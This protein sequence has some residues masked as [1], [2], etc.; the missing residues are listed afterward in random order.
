V[1]RLSKKGTQRREEVLRT[2]R[3]LL[4]DEGRAGFSMRRVA[5]RAGMSL[6]NL[7][8]YFPTQ[9]ALVEALLDSILTQ[10]LHGL[11]QARGRARARPGREALAALVDRLLR[12]HR[13]PEL[14]RLFF[15]IWSL[16][17]H[18][19]GARR[20][21]ARFYARYRAAIAAEL[22]ATCPRPKAR[23]PD[24][25][26]AL[27]AL[28]EGSSLF[29]VGVAGPV[30][31]A[32]WTALRDAALALACVDERARAPGPCGPSRRTGSPSSGPASG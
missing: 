26:R 6:G 16:A 14:C 15:E 17:S 3:D 27:L 12:Y 10:S 1:T 4:V 2:A 30:G 21:T 24:P 8:H 23:R 19:D 18:D 22:A 28:I 32:G 5:E 9:G 20:A 25:S 7:Q 11:E 13:D 31:P 29:A